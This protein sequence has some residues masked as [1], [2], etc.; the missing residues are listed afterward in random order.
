MNY[1]ITAIK[2]FNLTILL[3][4]VFYNT[5]YAQD[6]VLDSL[7]GVIDNSNVS[8]EDKIDTYN[9]LANQTPLDDST[10]FFLYINKSRKLSKENDYVEGLIDANNI[11][12]Y[13]YI[14]QKDFEKAQLI[15]ET[16][17]KK[18]KE[19]KYK[20]GEA[21]GHYSL[22]KLYRTQRNFQGAIEKYNEAIVIY[23]NTDDQ[24]KVGKTYKDIALAY[25]YLGEYDKSII[26]YKTAIQ[27]Y[28][29]LENY[30]ELAS[31]YNNLGVVYKRKSEYDRALEYYEK[32]VKI[33]ET[34]GNDKG[35][36]KLYNNLGSMQEARGFYAQA[37]QYYQKSLKIKEKLGD[38]E[39]LGVA[40]INIGS[41]HQV[42]ASYDLALEYYQKAKELYKE[43]D[44]QDYLS[45]AY[46]NLGNVYELKTEY[47]IATMYYE[48]SLKLM[49]QLG[50]KSGKATIY[51]SF[52]NLNLIKEQYQAAIEF[53]KLSIQLREELGE[54]AALANSYIEL[55]RVYYQLKDYKRALPILNKGVDLGKAHQELQAV[56]TGAQ[57]L[58]TIYSEQGNYQQAYKN[59]VLFREMK[60]SLSNTENTKLITR[61]ESEYAFQKVEDSLHKENIIQAEQIEKDK[62]ESKF[63]RNINILILVILIIVFIAAV[64][65]YRS[66]TKTKKLNNQLNQQKKT[67]AEVNGE[68]Q[69]L[70]EELQQNQDEIIAQRDS[71]ESQNQLL[72][73]QH[74]NIA[75]SI[76]AAQT[77]QDAILPYEE[78]M[79][80][81]LKDFFLI[82]RPRDVVSGD[83]YWL[84]SQNGKK[85]VGAL[86]C[87]GHGV[88]GAFM[89]M[90]GF[91]LLNEIINTKKV[92]EPAQ[93]L[94]Q[95]RSDIRIALRQ[96]ETGMSNGMD[97]VFVTIEDDNDSQ[98]KKVTVAG[99]KCPLWYVN[100]DKNEVEK[101]K[102]SNISIGLNY[103][104]VRNFES[105]TL[106]LPKG[107]L[108]YFGSDGIIDQND[109][110]KKKFGSVRL[111][112]VLEQNTTLSLQEQK[113][114][115]EN[116]I[117][118]H[119]K[120]TTQ[121]DDILWIGIR[122]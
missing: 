59:E 118:N 105:T 63:Q 97:A 83:F 113:Q 14:R 119:M 18:A 99:A 66:Q 65:I 6:E 70:N 64:F 8:I 47:D 108:L 115:L 121:R 80:E 72:E 43:V 104:E 15:Y 89:S 45:Y 74:Q 42:Q 23:K 39:S 122:V 4:F 1:Y 58:S 106:L 84:S 101:I 48:K 62:I 73:E 95:L 22:G 49:E 40:Y 38:K 71:I 2:Y 78:R 77:I 102:G 25:I 79:K 5:S 30:K 86:D 81:E 29:S 67:L 36:V 112:E 3:S 98:M 116:Q 31:I 17:I 56:R 52:T 114:N 69:G 16:S 96:N 55:G 46:I 24:E 44:S 93:I 7:Q 19:N 109:I 117:D 28:E 34:L 32:A 103:K 12:G 10:N 37:L 33:E 26:S 60:D 57:M 92:T 50:D 53:G 54:K 100:A 27:I 68:L 35:I 41:I 82:Y 120:N 76:N 87:T 20:E 90:I 110:N 94:E 75:Q 91:T 21:D 85:I 61:L 13:Y 88:S 51:H 9:Q 11:S 111:K 107:S